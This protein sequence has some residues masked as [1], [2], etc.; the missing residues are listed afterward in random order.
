MCTSVRGAVV[1][2]ILLCVGRAVSLIV[3]H[4]RPVSLVNFACQ[5]T[6]ASDESERLQNKKWRNKKEK[7]LRCSRRTTTQTPTV[8]QRMRRQADRQAHS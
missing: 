3:F 4:F 7:A 8:P 2:L 1:G 6:R 5:R